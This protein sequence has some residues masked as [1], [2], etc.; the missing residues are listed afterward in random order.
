MARTKGS[1]AEQTQARENEALQLLTSG[2]SRAAVVAELAAKHGV[3]PRTARQWTQA[4]MLECYMAPNTENEVG[5][6]WTNQVERLEL[7]SDKAL[8]D[9]DAKLAIQATKAAGSLYSQRLAALE[10]MRM[11]GQRLGLQF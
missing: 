3:T 1:T 10:R 8:Q 7:L 4:A 11:T 9:G 2:R 5:F 6:G